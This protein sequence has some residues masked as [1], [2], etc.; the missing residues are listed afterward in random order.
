VLARLPPLLL[1]LEGLAVLAAALVLYF[2]QDFGWVLLVVLFLAPDVSFAGYL[3]GPRLGAVAYDTLHTELL[4]IALGVLGIVA[5][6][7][8]AIQLALIWLAHI[9][10]DRLLGYGLKYPIQFADTH[11]QRL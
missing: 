10:G 7:T 8:T 3:L 5:D 1:R 11:L 2:H 9:G 6:V 4:P